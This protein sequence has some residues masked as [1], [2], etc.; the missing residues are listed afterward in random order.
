[1]TVAKV[2]EI[3]RN[4]QFVGLTIDDVE[5]PMKMVQQ[6]VEELA[7][8]IHQLYE[9]KGDKP[10]VLS[11]EEIEEVRSNLE[12]ECQDEELTDVEW[13]ELVWREI[14]QAQLAKC[15]KD[16]KEKME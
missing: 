8:E 13:E 16:L 11:D 2:K 15:K 7:Q 10:P 6:D 1:M 9:P 4:R 12:D 3:L 5:H 14:A